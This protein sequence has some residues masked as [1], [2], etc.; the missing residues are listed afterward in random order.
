MHKERKRLYN[1]FSTLF[2]KMKFEQLMD[3]LNMNALTFLNIKL[4]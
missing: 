1:I 4:Y 3:I 2:L